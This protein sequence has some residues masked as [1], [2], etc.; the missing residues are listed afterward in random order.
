MN[1][2]V[3]GIYEGGIVEYLINVLSLSIIYIVFKNNK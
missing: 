2:S 1:D 3:V